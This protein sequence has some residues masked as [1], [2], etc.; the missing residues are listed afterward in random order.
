M[1]APSQLAVVVTTVESME[2]ADRLARDLVDQSLVACAQID[3]PIVRHYRW[4]GKVEK[5][6]EF[7]LMLKTTHTAWPALKEKLA[8]SHPYDEPENILLPVAD[9]SDGY[10]AWVVEQTT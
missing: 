7:R 9:A 10:L 4:A 5:A 8:K 2:D 1:A 6:S 3:G